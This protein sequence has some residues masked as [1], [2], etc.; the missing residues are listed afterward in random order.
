MVADNLTIIGSSHIS[1]ESVKEI[2]GVLEEDVD[3]VCLEL[4]K[5]RFHSLLH[6][7]KQK[8]RLADIRRIGIKG[9]LFAIV[10][11]WGEEK[12]GKMVG[13]RPGVEMLEAIKIAQR[14]QIKI[15]LIDQEIEITLKRLSKA[16]TWREKFRFVREL[17]RFKRTI[18]FDIRTVP[19][20]QVI[21]TLVNE[22]RVKFPSVY[23]VLVEERNV[24]M[25]KRLN[26]L[27]KDHQDKHI[28]AIIGAGHVKGL[29][30]LLV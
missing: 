11:K 23:Q 15:G 19:T 1:P 5:G 18:P 9:W 7:K 12:L 27:V 29:K 22:M 4:D 10:A 28:V 21:E 26:R 14:R 3:I 16:I 25:A 20:E 2:Q 13:T 30:A 24:V 8:I 6:P 17:F